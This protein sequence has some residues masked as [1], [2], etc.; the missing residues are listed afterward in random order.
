MASQVRKAGFASLANACFAFEIAFAGLADACCRFEIA[1]AGL[2]DACCTFEIA[3]AGLAN[4]CCTF[5]IAFA[6]L[7]NACFAFEIAFAT[8]ADACFAFEIAFAGLADACCTFEIAARDEAMAALQARFV[9]FRELLTGLYGSAI[10]RDVFQGEAPRDPVTLARY[11]GEVAARLE[12]TKLPEPRQPGA[13]IDT[14]AVVDN[15][16]ALRKPLEESLK[17]VAKEVREA[18]VARQARNEAMDDYDRVFTG[19]ATLFEAFFLLGGQRDL[20]D[21]VRPSRRRPGTTEEEPTEP[22]EPTAPTDPQPT[23]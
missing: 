7:A 2:A 6:G 8:L 13:H 16:A 4:A 15:F 17:A 20:A 11:S 9:E 14:A 21:R 19:I 1:F 18:Q 23:A 10:S 5:E 3:F 12:Q 22:T